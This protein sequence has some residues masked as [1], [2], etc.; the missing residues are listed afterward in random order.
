MKE[1][2]LLTLTEEDFSNAGIDIKSINPQLLERIIEE[3]KERV[4]NEFQTELSIVYSM[5][6]KDHAQVTYIVWQGKQGFR[7]TQNTTS[8]KEEEAEKVIQAY[9]EDIWGDETEIEIDEEDEAL[10]LYS[11]TDNSHPDLTIITLEMPEYQWIAIAR[12][13]AD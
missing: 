13:L 1:K 5:I 11:Q 9:E 6:T 7:I 4:N 12:K 2:I 3:L 8:L 10:T